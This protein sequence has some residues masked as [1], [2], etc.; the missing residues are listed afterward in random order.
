MKISHT[1]LVLVL[2]AAVTACGEPGS[3]A[4]DVSTS[5]EAT[6]EQVVTES[7]SNDNES[8]EI[9]PGLNAII[10]KNGYGRA[11]EAGDMVD[12]HYTGWLFDEEAAD[13]LTVANS[14]RSRSVLAASFRVGIRVWS[15]C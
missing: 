6:E 11:A 13:R 3:P 12:V 4:E 7:A 2:A 1:L 10:I 9:T 14:S 8:F 15:E 5:N